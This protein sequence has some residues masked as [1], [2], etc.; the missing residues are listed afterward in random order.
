[1]RE[2]KMRP[3]TVRLSLVAVALVGLLAVGHPPTVAQESTLP[4]EG[5]TPP[6]RC[7]SRRSALP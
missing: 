3:L 5:F 1:M 6:R 7:T 4:S 2:G